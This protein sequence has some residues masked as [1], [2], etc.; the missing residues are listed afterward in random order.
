MD[1]RLQWIVA[2][3]LAYIAILMLT[4]VTTGDAAPWPTLRLA[5]PL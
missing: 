4:V 5:T 2:S 1:R 3:V